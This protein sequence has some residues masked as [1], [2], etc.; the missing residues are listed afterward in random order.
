MNSFVDNP[1]L[2]FVDDLTPAFTVNSVGDSRKIVELSDVGCDAMT[3][4]M[5]LQNNATDYS[6]RTTKMKEGSRSRYEEKSASKFCK[7]RLRQNDHVT[8]NVEKVYSI[9]KEDENLRQHRRKKSSAYD[10]VNVATISRIADTQGNKLNSTLPSGRPRSSYRNNEKF[11]ETQP[12]IHRDHDIVQ[13]NFRKESINDQLTTHKRQRA[14]RST[15]PTC[16]KFDV[17]INDEESITDKGKAVVTLEPDY[18]EIF[19]RNVSKDRWQTLKTAA[20]RNTKQFIDETLQKKQR[21]SKCHK[22]SKILSSTTA[23]EAARRLIESRV[24]KIRSRTNSPPND[25]QK[26]TRPF[27]KPPVKELERTKNVQNPKVC[28]SCK[29]PA[30]NLDFNRKRSLSFVRSS[31]KVRKFVDRAVDRDSLSEVLKVSTSIDA[32]VA[33]EP[34]NNTERNEEITGYW[35]FIPLDERNDKKYS[36]IK[37]WKPSCLDHRIHRDVNHPLTQYLM[38]KR[39]S[40][41]SESKENYNRR[42]TFD[43]DQ[44]MDL[45]NLKC[46]ESSLELNSTNSER[47]IKVN[48]KLETNPGFNENGTVNLNVETIRDTKEYSGNGQDRSWGDPVNQRKTNYV[49]SFGW[50]GKNQQLKRCNDTLKP[51]I[52]IDK[53]KKMNN[54][55]VDEKQA[56]MK[57]FGETAACLKRKLESQTKNAS[58]GKSSVP[59]IEKKIRSQVST[60]SRLPIRIGNRFKSKNPIAWKFLGNLKNRFPNKEKDRSPEVLNSVRSRTKPRIKSSIEHHNINVDSIKTSTCPRSVENF[61]TNEG[62]K[63][64]VQNRKGETKLIENGFMNGLIQNRKDEELGDKIVKCEVENLKY[65]NVEQESRKKDFANHLYGRRVSEEN[66]NVMNQ[67][68]IEVGRNS[69]KDKCFFH[70]HDEEN[71]ICNTY[72]N[73]NL[74]PSERGMNANQVTT[75]KV[76]L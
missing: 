27:S 30:D 22:N 23:G 11:H 29:S 44:K 5:I 8:G 38:N 33:P 52:V 37:N 39:D 51:E 72:C 62:I 9:S 10:D 61:Q 75:V 47:M 25:R 7:G 28:K 16:L 4:N 17:K 69:F 20:G 42:S 26:R 6:V 71:M 36:T 56:E 48:S 19:D 54:E 55:T 2:F 76:R 66:I 53:K 41:W 3:P 45:E 1:F 40:Y 46:Y 74:L 57:I 43:L 12:G 67:M 65:V 35:E 59:N 70:F 15:P 49:P 14:S 13:S 50:T 21:T 60:C 24:N 18:P 58:L 73:K 34:P 32:T 63:G 31:E 68:D 64:Y